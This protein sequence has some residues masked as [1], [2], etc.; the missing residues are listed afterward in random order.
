[1]E[2]AQEG[3]DLALV[4]AAEAVGPMDSSQRIPW[5]TIGIGGSGRLG[6]QTCTQVRGV[7][8]L[9]MPRTNA[10]VLDRPA[11]NRVA[12]AGDCSSGV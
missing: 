3:G 7:S 9:L 4:D 6:L 8:Q 12:H 1:V 11:C 2:L 10:D 5:P